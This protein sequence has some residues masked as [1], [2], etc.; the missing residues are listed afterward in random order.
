LIETV[1]KLRNTKKR[2]IK[3]IKVKDIKIWVNIEI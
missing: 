1:N 3:T 2:V